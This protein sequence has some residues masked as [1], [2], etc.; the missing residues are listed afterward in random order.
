MGTPNHYGD[1]ESL[2]GRRITAGSLKRSSNVASTFFNT[3]HLFSKDFRFEHGAPNLL[4]ARAPS[5]LVTPLEAKTLCLYKEQLCA[6]AALCSR[7]SEG[8]AE[9]LGPTGFVHCS[10]KVCF[11]SFE[12]EK[13]KFHHFWSPSEK[14]LEKSTSA[15]PPGKNPSDAFCAANTL[16]L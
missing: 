11:L 14:L 9:G 5:N 4:L 7:A 8:G 16:Y 3:V 12:W 1:A 6:V 13:N 15:P 10:K 2:W